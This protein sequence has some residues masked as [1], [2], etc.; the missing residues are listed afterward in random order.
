MQ[1][2]KAFMELFRALIDSIGVLGRNNVVCAQLCHSHAGNITAKQLNIVL[3]T[4][5]PYCATLLQPPH[6][7]MHHKVFPALAQKESS[8]KYLSLWTQKK[9]LN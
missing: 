6:F 2:Q 5:L 8:I 9:K 3:H 4:N 1:T 7:G